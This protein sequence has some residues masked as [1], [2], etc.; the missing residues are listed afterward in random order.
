MA[1]YDLITKEYLANRDRLKSGKYVQRLIKL[2]PKNATVL[3]LGCGAGMGVDD[4]LLK[5][6]HYVVGI[7]NSVE[8][9]KLARKYCFRGEYQIQDILDLEKNDYHLDA[10][11]SIYTWFHLPRERQLE[12][13]KVVASYLPV[14]GLLLITMG[15]REF[16]GEHTMYGGR[17]WVSQYSTEKN[18]KIVEQAGF[19]IIFEEI[20]SSGGERHQWL[21]ASK[22]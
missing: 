15:D 17:V 7:D 8:Q 1:D 11:V 18:R 10:V 22:R 12:R 5:A 3:D 16:E 19:K 21:L 4:I 13:L 20:D 2:L 9:I 6:G 14:G